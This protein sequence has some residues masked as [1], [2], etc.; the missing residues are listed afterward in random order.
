MHRSSLRGRTLLRTAP[1]GGAM[2]E[3]ALVMPFLVGLAVG[4]FDLG[5]GLWQSM[6]VRAAAEAGAQYA[7][8]HPD[9]WDAAKIAAV[10]AA[11]TGATGASGISATPAPSQ[12]CGCTNNGAFTPVGSPTGGSCGSFA[13]SPSGTPGLYA[14][15]SA[16]MPY[17]PLVP[18][19]WAKQP[20]AALT[21][22]AY[23]RLK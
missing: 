20:P 2:I 13:C 5:F 16:Q 15:V 23:R 3:F 21:G 14:S 17:S 4:L 9:P 1:C 6:Q 10:G 8:L 7:A 18:W 22:Q 12:V 19:P 11:V